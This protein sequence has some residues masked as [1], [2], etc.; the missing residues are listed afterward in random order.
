MNNDEYISATQKF[1][2]DELTLFSSAHWR[3][4]LRVKQITLGSLVLLPVDPIEDFDAATPDVAADFF[5]TVAL[6]QSVLKKS[7]T[8][9]RYNVIA[10]MMKDAFV[11][12][13][14]IPRYSTEREFANETWTDSDWPQLVAFRDVDTDR[15]TR[16][17]LVDVLTQA[18]GRL[19]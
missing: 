5:R 2:P 9:D 6:S 4:L 17:L 18:F 7:F 15:A 3:V 8:P 19:R 10:A 12:F 13:H 14:L 1:R 16:E 11:H